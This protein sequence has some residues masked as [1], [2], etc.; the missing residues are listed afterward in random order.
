VKNQQH[1]IFKS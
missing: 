1:S